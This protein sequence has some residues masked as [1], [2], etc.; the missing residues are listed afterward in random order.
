MTTNEEAPVILDEGDKMSVPK[1]PPE[2]FSPGKKLPRKFT[3]DEV[4]QRNALRDYGP[5]IAGDVYKELEDFQGYFSDQWDSKLQQSLLKKVTEEYIGLEQQEEILDVPLKPLD[6]EMDIMDDNTVV[7]VGKR[8]SGK[9][10]LAR[11]IMYHLK[12]RFPAG[13]VITGTKLNGFWQQ[14]VPANFIHQVENLNEVIDRVCVRQEFFIKNADVLGLSHKFFVILDDVLE[15]E[16]LIRYS[17]GLRKLFCNGRHFK[18][19][20]MVILQDPL[21]IPPKL[22]ENTDVAIIFRQ[23]TESRMEACRSVYLDFIQGKENQKQFLIKHTAKKNPEDGSDFDS[24]TFIKEIQLARIAAM[25]LRQEPRKTD[26]PPDK[27]EK[28]KETINK[29]IEKGVPQVLCCIT[30]E[31]TDNLLDIFKIAIAE[32]PGPFRL[33]DSRYWAAM[34]TGRWMHLRKTFDEFIRQKPRTLA[35]P[36]SKKKKQQSK[37]ILRK[38]K[39]I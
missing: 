38:N 5:G 16:N 6:V 36:Q 12:H 18:L 7:I 30:A 1:K 28:L 20:L 21:G 26:D 2:V 14:Y 34:Q 8:R 33:G 13:V 3:P 24:K 4:K 15:D 22:R 11:W 23:F 39:P 29:K 19:F 27:Q 31:T 32:D 9:S 17:R 35:Q 37:S 25:R 10:F